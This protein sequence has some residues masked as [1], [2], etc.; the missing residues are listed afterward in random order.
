MLRGNLFGGFPENLPQ[1]LFE[2][3]VETVS[4]RLE[5]I[6]SAG[7][8]TPA[9]EW[10]DQERPE[11][12]VLL[13]GSA[14]LRFEEHPEI[15]VLKPDDFLLIPAHERHRVEWTDPRVK[16]VWLALHY[17]PGMSWLASSKPLDKPPGKR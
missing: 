5:R 11:W 16:T 2:T 9:G 1:E 14:G 10:Y 15:V 7:H 3:L 6:V 13:C 12:V 17:D 4:L 8:A